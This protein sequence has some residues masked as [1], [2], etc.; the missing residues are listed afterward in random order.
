MPST[1]TK[2]STPASVA[3]PPAAKKGKAQLNNAI[4]APLN[5]PTLIKLQEGL[6]T[7]GVRDFLK[8]GDHA[9]P[10]GGL[11][12]FSLDAYKAAMKKSKEYTCVVSAASIDPLKTVHLNI[13]PSVGT[14]QS[15][16]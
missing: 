9:K 11:D 13:I 16:P 1:P 10:Y 15:C 5:H 4:A 8:G 6:A 2:R 3:T 14:L 7:S 12:E